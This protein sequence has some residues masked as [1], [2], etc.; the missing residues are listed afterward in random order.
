MAK[1]DNQPEVM[2]ELEKAQNTMATITETMNDDR[3]LVN[4]LLGQIQ[5]ARSFSRFADVVSINK[6]KH[7]K[8]TKQYKALAG[9]KGYDL[10]GN[11]IADVGT[12]DGFCQAIGLSRS[13]VDE[14][15]L[16]LEA[17]GEETLKQ[18]SSIGA[19]YRE[20][21]QFRKLPE[22]EKQALIEVAKEG[23]KEG[24]AEVA[25]T[26][27]AKHAKEKE[28]LVKELEDK[29]SDY[30]ELSKINEEKSRSL[31]KARTELEKTKKRIKALSPVDIGEQIRN[32]AKDHALIA[33]KAIRNSLQSALQALMDHGTEHDINHRPFMEGLIGQVS[34][35]LNELKI[36]FNLTGI[37]DDD[38]TP[39]WMRPEALEEAEAAL[40]NEPSGDNE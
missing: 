20:L 5:M 27:I 6:L 13:K 31:D 7:I 15:I 22:D 17:F 10:N 30:E 37:V 21:R 36:T 8:E 25:E 23:D 29:K 18:L 11:E 24:F 26:I 9:K 38:P 35:A 33:E 32:E 2:Q 40:D 34:M 3:D 28:A 19:G 12:W 14:D 16:N 1:K 39:H 4:Q